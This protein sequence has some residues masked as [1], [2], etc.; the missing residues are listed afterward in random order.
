M[1]SAGIWKH[2]TTGINFAAWVMAED[3]E[4]WKGEIGCIITVPL[5]VEAEPVL[6]VSGIFAQKRFNEN[7]L[8]V[9]K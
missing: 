2:K 7:F 8:F 4:Q 5:K 6:T 9:K 3:G 1:K